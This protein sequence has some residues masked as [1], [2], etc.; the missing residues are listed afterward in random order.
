MDHMVSKWPINVCFL[1]KSPLAQAIDALMYTGKTDCLERPLIFASMD[2]DYYLASAFLR[3]T[4]IE[5]LYGQMA[6]A[7]EKMKGIVD[8]FSSS[9]EPE[10]TGFNSPSVEAYLTY[11]EF[12]A[13]TTAA[14]VLQDKLLKLIR[15]PVFYESKY[16]VPESMYNYVSKER[17]D[18]F[19]AVIKNYWLN[20]GH[21]LRD[22]RVLVNH[23]DRVTPWP[24]YSY[25]ATK[26]HLYLP[27]PSNPDVNSH[28][29]M[30]YNGPDLKDFTALSLSE[31]QKVTLE[32]TS[33]ISERIGLYA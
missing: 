18:Y 6:I 32:I 1:R 20:S 21:V 12:D 33:I 4:K 14:R 3:Y 10:V 19:Y 16:K 23:Y 29:K 13:Y 25:N 8:S 2:C 27:L 22:Y 26:R 11:M 17:N 31:L 15:S 9:S 30:I 28:K 5:A 24:S 7:A